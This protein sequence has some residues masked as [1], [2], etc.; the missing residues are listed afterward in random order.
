[1][2]GAP[3]TYAVVTPAHDEA[4]HLPRLAASLEEQSVLPVAW[5]IVDDGSH[6]ATAELAGSLTRTHPWIHLHRLAPTV[7]RATRGAPVVRAFHAGLP[8]ARAARPDVIV[9]LDADLSFDAAFFEGL[10]AQFAAAPRLG[11]ASGVCLEQDASGTWQRRY[12]T[13]TGVWGACR[14]Y[15]VECLDEI[16]SLEERQGWD[17]I[18]A[19]KAVV[20][21]WQTTAFDELEFLHHR[22][23]GERDGSRIRVWTAQGDVAH[24]IGYRPSYVL[25]RTLF[26][27]R[28]EPAAVALLGGYLTAAARQKPRLDDRAAVTHL[29]ESQRL[30][31][32]RNRAREARGLTAVAPSA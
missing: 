8:L 3:L 9:K 22:R 29:R 6:D 19:L 5:V 1:M 25:L 12:G 16:G 15:R 31:N 17:E 13:G 27:A 11:I 20:R 18:D 10:L 24:F 14:A 26:R 7:S 28:R 32:L 30:R 23:E 2:T 4:E 21:G